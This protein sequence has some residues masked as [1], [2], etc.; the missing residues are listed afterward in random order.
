MDN[1]DDPTINHLP[2]LASDRNPILLSHRVQFS[3]WNTPFKFEEM[4]MSHDTLYAVVENSWAVPC[5]GSPQYILA[6]KLKYLKSNLQTWNREVFGQLNKKILDV[7]KE[8]LEAQIAFD[9]DIS[10]LLL[11]GLNDAKDDLH[12]WLNAESAHWK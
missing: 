3:P 6:K 12:S 5:S 2:R 11:K 4:R 10:E 1:S 9:S 7:K 8:V